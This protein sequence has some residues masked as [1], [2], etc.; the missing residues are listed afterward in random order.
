MRKFFARITLY[1]LK[2]EFCQ[3]SWAESLINLQLTGK[4]LITF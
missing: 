1:E 3:I 4:I 2:F